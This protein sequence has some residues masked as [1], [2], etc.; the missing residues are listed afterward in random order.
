MVIKID[1]LSKSF[2][3][4][5]VLD[6]V[7]LVLTSGI[8]LLKGASGSGKTTFA[9]I[10]CSLEKSD[11]G[12]ISTFSVS[13]M[14]Q[15]PRLFPWMTALDN[16]QKISGCD[17]EKAN[18]LLSSLELNNEMK[19]LPHELSVGMQRR[20]SLARTLAQK[21]ELYV[22]DEP[23]AGLDERMREIS[24][25]L[26]RKTIPADSTAIIISHDTKEIEKISDFKLTLVNRKISAD[27]S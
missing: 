14:F 26:I 22:F 19:A 15:E 2:E 6:N 9:R 12:T 8:Y 13:Y 3:G 18:F 27:K 20:V 7:S 16:V 21:A 10:L 5:K 1:G 4:K 23:M 11:S 24:C 25:N 17:I